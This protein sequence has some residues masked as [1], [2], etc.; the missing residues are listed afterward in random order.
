MSKQPLIEQLD[1]AVVELLASGAM[2]AS[3]DTSI[4]DLLRIAQDLRELPTPE[5]KARLRGELERKAQ[6]SA[7]TVVFRPGFRTVTPDRKSTRLN[8]SH[9]QSSDAV[10]CFA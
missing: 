1:Q 6:M 5:F 9:S 2:P 8:S 10:V 4:V 3:V 7:K